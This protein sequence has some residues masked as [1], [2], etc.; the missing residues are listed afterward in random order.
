MREFTCPVSN[1]GL[2]AMLKRLNEEVL[3]AVDAPLTRKTE[4][5]HRN[6][7]VTC[8]VHGDRRVMEKGHHISM[9]IAKA[10]T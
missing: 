3:L 9:A 8:P 1:C 4:F 7:I 2:V 5:L 10:A 6:F